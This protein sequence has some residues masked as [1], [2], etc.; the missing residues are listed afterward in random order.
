MGLQTEV[1]LQPTLGLIGPTFK[2]A[3]AR[4]AL[5]Y[6]DPDLRLAPNPESV[7]VEPRFIH[8]EWIHP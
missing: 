5:H 2:I 1:T 6:P 7:I 8:P 4:R 3:P